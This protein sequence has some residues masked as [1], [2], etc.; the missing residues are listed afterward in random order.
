MMKIWS[1]HL[2]VICLFYLALPLA[3]LA[4]DTPLRVEQVLDKLEKK[5]TGK[6]FEAYFDQVTTMAALGLEDESS[7]KVWFSHPGKMRWQYL[8]PHH[9]EYI[10]DG[11][12]LWFYQ[13]LENQV[14]IGKAEEAFKNG[15][16]GNFLS[17][18]SMVRLNYTCSV[19]EQSESDITLKLIP[20]K[21]SSAVMAIEIQLGLSDFIIHQVTTWNQQKDI[22][23]FK[24]TKIH[25]AESHP[26]MFSFTPPEGTV[27]IQN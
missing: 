20:K 9:H 23:R 2:L 16:G 8:L 12:T 25:F 18:F 14:Q 11:E 3:L 6:S 4:S 24:F 13:P 7:G 21:P 26:A 10:T 22:T 17:D 5:Y 19:K 1:K 15:A 27:V